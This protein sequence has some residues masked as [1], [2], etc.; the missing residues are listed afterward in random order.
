SDI[1]ALGAVIYELLTGCTPYDGDTFH[2]LYYAMSKGAPLAPSTARRDVPPELD[3]VILRCLELDP[4]DRYTDVA[5]VADALLPFAPPGSE[6][7]V[8]RIERVLEASQVRG[9]PGDTEVELL[10]KPASSG[11]KRRALPPKRSRRLR[12]NGRVVRV[13]TVAIAAATI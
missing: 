1:W 8:V 2:E 10:R 7:R 5:D 12:G 11:I 3:R 13:A 4:G 9:Q 6:A